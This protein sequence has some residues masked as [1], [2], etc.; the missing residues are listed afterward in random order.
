MDLCFSFLES[1][2]TMFF[3]KVHWW[4]NF[5]LTFILK[6]HFY[7]LWDIVTHWDWHILL[8]YYVWWQINE[9]SNL[10][11]GSSFIFHDCFQH[12][13]LSWSTVW[14]LH[15]KVKD[16]YYIFFAFLKCRLHWVII[17]SYMISTKNLFSLKF[18]VDNVLL[19]LCSM[20]LSSIYSLYVFLCCI[21]NQVHLAQHLKHSIY[22]L[23][24]TTFITI[25]SFL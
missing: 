17:T 23:I 15:I 2:L 19:L 24:A 16:D 18:W 7:F 20:N 1:I 9:L 11:H 3:R 14:H 25:I 6:I 13:S 21:F 8:T 12:L 5:Y 10:L 4:A 22:C